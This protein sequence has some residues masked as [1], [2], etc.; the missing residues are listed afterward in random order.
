MTI[1]PVV[2][3]GKGPSAQPVPASDTYVVAAVNDATRFCERV[4]FVFV[5]DIEILDCMGPEDFAKSD[6]AVVPTHPF[7]EHNQYAHLTHLDLLKQMRGISQFRLYQPR[8]ENPD[9]ELQ[10]GIEHFPD[11]Y[12]GGDAAVAWLVARGFREFYFVGIDPAGGYHE[13]V[14]AS[15]EALELRKNVVIGCPHCKKDFQ[16]S[17]S[18][19]HPV[20]N[21]KKEAWFRRQYHS[22][23][24]KSVCAGGSFHHLA[25]G[26]PMPG[27]R[28]AS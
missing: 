24:R 2:L 28:A 14:V 8:F 25:H 3:V 21:P 20:H 12:S 9:L 1:K 13:D 18:L 17:I 26:E 27:A 15:G 11:I 23:T 4:D 6:C 5:Q 7:R 22:M 10:D 16:A 19:A